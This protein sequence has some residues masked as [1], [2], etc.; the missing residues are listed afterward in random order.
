MT[1][2]RSSVV[3]LAK[4]PASG[5]DPGVESPRLD[6][7]KSA[8]HLHPYVSVLS[9]G[10]DHF[11]VSR[12]TAGQWPVAQPTMLRKGHRGARIDDY[13]GGV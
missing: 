4:A 6:Y 7:R 5:A 1:G 8:T 2:L 11:R 12:E 9:D 13:L 3:D 10:R